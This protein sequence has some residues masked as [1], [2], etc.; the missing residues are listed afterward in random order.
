MKLAVD[1]IQILAMQ[2]WRLLGFK[3]YNASILCFNA[4]VKRVK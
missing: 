2:Q 1:L 4:S 3:F